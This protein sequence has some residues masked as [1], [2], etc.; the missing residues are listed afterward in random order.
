MHN[1]ILA[2]V[3][4]LCLGIMIFSLQDPLIKAVSGR[5]PVMEV[6]AIRSVVALP[7]LLLIVHRD[8]GLAALVSRSFGLLTLRALTLF[9][10]YTAY[11]LALAALPMANAIALYFMAP[12]FIMVLAGPYLGERVSWQSFAAVSVG[13]VGVLVMLRPGG[14]VFEWAALLSLLSA[15]LYGFAQMTA[16]KLG[17][18]ESPTVMSFYQNG[19][20]L[21]GALVTAGIFAVSNPGDFAHPSLRFLTRSWV[22]P[23][24]GD[25]LMMA[26]CGVI[27]SAGMILLSQ[28]YRLAPANIVATFE[29]SGI[30]WTPLW[31][32]LFFAEVPHA[33]TIFGAALIVGAGI[34]AL[35]GRAGGRVA[36]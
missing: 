5:Y 13:L 4:S 36:A 3:V 27:A 21:L 15:G 33:A 9:S 29:Y 8:V 11:Y 31:G 16:R 34:F 10:S 18:T 23:D 7:I 17:T 30:L 35:N 1:R 26:S 24:T 14:D 22:W 2:G 32:F 6:M 19:I 12:L 28:A 20:Y 25:F